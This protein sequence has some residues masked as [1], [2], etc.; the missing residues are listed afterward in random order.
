MKKETIINEILK[1][2]WV[3]II[4][5]IAG[6]IFETIVVILQT[7]HF[8]IRQGLIYGPFIPVYGIGLVMYYSIFKFIKTRDKI[9]IFLITLALGGLTEYVCSYLQEIIFGSISWD[10]S[11]LPFNLHGRT[12]L[13]HCT[14][15][16]IAGLLY[17]SWIEPLL[18]ELENIMQDTR[19][20]IIT[21]LLAIFII[22]DVSISWM[23]IARQK[24]RFLGENPRNAIEQFLDAY[25]PDDF[26]DTI[27]SNKKNKLQVQEEI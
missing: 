12:S 2:F 27:F 18:H 26:I 24:N 19:L 15:W 3:F 5:S 13:L 21:I 1:I 25:Y 23:A 17:I 4:G 8:E 20:K 10:Y 9:K 6:W 22:I 14:Y 11:K 7:G 16:G